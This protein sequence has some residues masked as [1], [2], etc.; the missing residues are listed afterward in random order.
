MTLTQVWGALLIFVL[1]PVVG[2]LPLTGWAT[3]LL[4]GQQL[5]RVGTG[6]VGVSAAFYHGGKIAGIAAV[7]LEAA[8][9]IGI[10][11]LAQYYF[12]ADPVWQIIALIFL[13]MGRYWF[14]QGAGTTNVVWGIVAFDWGTALLT[15]LLS[16][17]GFTI[18]RERRQGRLLALVLLPLITALRHADGALVAAM[19]CLSLLIAWIYQ[20]LPDDL[21]LPDDKGRLESRTMFRFFRGDR[22]LVALDQPLDATKFG[23]K[24]A[25]LGQ[26]SAWGYPVPRGYVLPAGDDPAALLAIAAP[27]SQQ[28]LAVRSSAQDEDTGTASAA[29]IYRSILNV[30]DGDSLAEAILRVFSSYNSQRALAYRQSLGL[31]ERGLAVIVQQQVQ[32]QFSGVAFSRDPIT[33]CGDAVVIEALPGGAEQVVGGQVT[34]EQYRVL[35]Q[36]D[37][38]P[39]MADIAEAD[40]QLSEALTL[41][42]DGSGQTPSRLLQQVAYLARHLESRFQG[43]P[44]D[45]EWSFDGETL[46]LL[47]S[48]PITTLQPL[49]TR[50]IAAEVIPGTI[51]PLTWSINRP[52]TCGVWGEIFTIVLGDRAEGLDFEATATL[53]HAHAYFNAT[54]LGDIFRRMGLPAES[55]EF[56][57]RGAKFNRPPLGSTLR[58]LPGL[59]RLLRCEIV[60]EQ[61]FRQANGAVYSPALE[62]LAASPRDH[63][64][65]SELIE[66]VETILDLLRQVTY[67]NILGP[68]SFALRR[69]LLGV[70]ETDLDP[71]RSA[72]I[73]ALDDLR[74]I[75]QDIRQ[76][77]STAELDRIGHGSSLMT[78]LAESTDGENLLHQIDQFIANYGYLSPVGTDIAVATWRENPTPVRELLAQFVQQPPRPK[79]PA[80]TSQGGKVALVQQRL[81][82]KGQVN[83]L[84]NQLLAEL[85]WS[86]LAL[87][88]QWQ[89]QGHLEAVD[90]IF[91]LTLEE[92]QALVKAENALPWAVIRQRIGDRTTQYEQDKTLSSLPYLVFGNEPP[93]RDTPLV[94]SA[95][96]QQQLK[97]IGASAGLVTGPV[98]VVTQLESIP[99]GDG[100]FILVVPYTDAGWAP[101]LARAQGLIAEVGGRLSHGAIVA[102]EY[103]IPAVMDITDATRRLHTGQWVRLNGESGLVEILEPPTTAPL[104]LEAGPD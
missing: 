20:K 44:Q 69:A 49:W 11:L 95:T 67:Y 104:A 17:L 9:G 24:A 60:L 48:R 88:S 65:P 38:V 13:V 39:P 73:A 31:P 75:A 45:I 58:N 33:R 7:M 68:L 51:R 79:P 47:Q 77:L 86:I 61:Q 82:L 57:T 53:H 76:V 2:G 50:K 52:L 12:P 18:F 101:L 72:E 99:T 37:D 94:S 30:T 6:N 43:V 84:Y 21:D 54:L 42:V 96:V 46:W 55:L 89:Q 28:P 22:G 35:V 92:I 32:G 62:T 23:H 1:A 71:S 80:A 59:L 29:G 78:T 25:M 63:L 34:P 40:W 83:T 100:P 102:R 91:F 103:G 81:D 87:A 74:A 5:Q 56:L 70:P 85:R 64:S 26:L 90:D 15:F 14:A 36:P 97:G 16:G 4:S 8:K 3:R 27:S 93:S 19:A 98:R 41:T 66:R 10:V